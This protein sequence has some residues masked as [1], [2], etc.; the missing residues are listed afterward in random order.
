MQL[1]LAAYGDYGGAWWSGSPERTGTDVGIGLR[2][3]QTAGAAD[4]CSRRIDL[5][6]RFANDAV[7]SGWIVSIG[8]GFVFTPGR[9]AARGA[10]PRC[11]ARARPG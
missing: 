1:G 8:R 7:G 2:I 10:R 4:V 6:W 9:A 5:S 11:R 3:G